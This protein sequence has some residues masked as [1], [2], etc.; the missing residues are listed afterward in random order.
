MFKRTF[1]IVMDS[2]G[3]GEAPDAAAFNDLNTHTIRHT[4]ESKGSIQLPTLEVLGL[5]HLTEI[6]GI[7][8]KAKQAAYAR[9][10]ETSAGK[11]TMTGHWELMGLQIDVPF[12]T[13]TETGFPEDL[14]KSLEEKWGR[15]IIGNKA[16]SGT[17][18][19]KELGPEHVKTGDLIVYTSADSVLQIAAHEDVVPL[20]ELYQACEIARELTL[21]GPY[22]LGRIIARP[23]I[24][25]E[26]AGF[27]RTANRHDYALKPFAKTTLDY[28]KEAGLS[29]LAFG[30]I[31]D[32]YDGEG[33]TKSR[34]QA[35]NDEGM[36]HFTEALEEDFEGL[37]FLNLVDFDA[38]YGH[39]RD[40]K[41]YHR[42]LETF[43]AQ[44]KTFI[45]QMR[46]DDLLMVTA[47]HGN[48]PTHIGTDHTREYVP[49]LIHSKRFNSSKH[50][51]DLMS[52]SSLGA[53][54]SDIYG[55]P[56]TPHG[57]SFYPQIKTLME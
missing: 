2:V 8:P 13:F 45:N 47:D 9:M 18:I 57:T 52:F 10:Q 7:E 56:K 48:D 5:G 54:I 14:I 26:E 44:L 49:L 24:G 39:R 27:T 41:G 15:K 17:E 32:I 29:V 43:D 22:K 21:E 53:T 1:V 40:P 12:Q 30:K 23:F 46:D 42:A 51:G 37:A 55:V 35:S 16:A 4:A 20:D 31:A 36:K 11:D 38:L 6:P 25:S 50:L 34:R 33:I 3:I 28:L 19:I